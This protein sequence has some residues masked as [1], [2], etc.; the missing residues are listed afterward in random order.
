MER[1][2]LDIPQHH[3]TLGE[4]ALSMGQ[5]IRLKEGDVVPVQINEGVEVRVEDN[6]MFVAEMVKLRQVAVSLTKRI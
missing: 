6:A 1:A 5:L 4:P 3:S 2:I